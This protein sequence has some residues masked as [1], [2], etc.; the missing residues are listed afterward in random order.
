MRGVHRVKGGHELVVVDAQLLVQRQAL[1]ELADLARGERRVRPRQ[2]S[3]GSEAPGERRAEAGRRESTRVVCIEA[4]EGLARDRARFRVLSAGSA[5]PCKAGELL[6]HS[7]RAAPSSV[8]AGHR[9]RRWRSL[10]SRARG[11]TVADP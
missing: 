6:M 10:S 9:G 4:A 8:R 2:L 7:S 1:H 11:V 5:P 3:V